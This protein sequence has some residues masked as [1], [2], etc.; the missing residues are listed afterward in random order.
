LPDPA[1]RTELRTDP[2]APRCNVVPVPAQLLSKSG[3]D[4]MTVDRKNLESVMA[5]LLTRFA[6]LTHKLPPPGKF[7][8]G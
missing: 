3:G 2:S 5:M 6:S 7:E 8:R 4:C 1:G